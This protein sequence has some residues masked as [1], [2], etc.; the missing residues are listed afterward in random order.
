MELSKEL[1][2]DTDVNTIDW[3]KNARYVIERVVTRGNLQDWEEIQ[4]FYGL[5]VIKEKVLQIRS[6]NKKTL[7]FLS[8]YFDTPLTDFRC[9]NITQSTRQHWNY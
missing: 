2:W 7:N 8:F 9:Y 6:M 3:E 1:F 4:K 5:E